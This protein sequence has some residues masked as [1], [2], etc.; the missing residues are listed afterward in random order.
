[1]SEELFPDTLLIFRV[2]ARFGGRRTD[3]RGEEVVQMRRPELEPGD[4]V[5]QG[6]DGLEARI[7]EF[8]DAGATK[9]VVMPSQEPDEWGPELDLL[10]DA[11]LHFHA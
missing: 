6:R 3:E 9:F 10:A 8:C 4:I 11:I 7:K 5:V 2:L 1:M